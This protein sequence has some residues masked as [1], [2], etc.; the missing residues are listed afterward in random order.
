MKNLILVLGG[1]GSG[2]GTLVS[3]LAEITNFKYVEVGKLLRSFPKESEVYKTISK[4]D[5]VPNHILFELLTNILKSNEDIV[6]DGFPRNKDQSK[7]MLD[8][9]KN[10]STLKVVFLNLSF[11]RMKNR[12]MQRLSEGSD[13]EDDKDVEV[14]M[15]RLYNYKNLTLP[16]VS[17]LKENLNK[18]NFIEVNVE[19]GVLNHI[20]E[21]F[22]NLYL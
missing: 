17:Y 18:E 8:N 21:I 6:I 19:D 13:R 5:F 2:K 7:W 4:G 1:P 22:N 10:K 9:Y 12:I 11:D 14:V 16:A 3:K 15:H 20:D